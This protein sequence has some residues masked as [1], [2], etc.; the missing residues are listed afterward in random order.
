MKLKCHVLFMLD[1]VHPAYIFM[2]FDTCITMGA[3]LAYIYIE[4]QA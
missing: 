3:M 2:V 4:I 1:L